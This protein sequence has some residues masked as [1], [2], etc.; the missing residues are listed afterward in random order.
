MAGREQIAVVRHVPLSVLN[1]RIKH[2]KG[3]PQVVP[4]LVFIRL[5]Y[6]GMSV[7]DAAE[8]VGSLIRLVTTGR[9]AGTRRGRSG[10]FRSMPVATLRN[11]L[12]SR[13][14]LCLKNSGRK[15]TGRPP[16]SSTGSSRSSAS[17]T[18]WTRSGGSSNRLACSPGNPIRG[19]TADPSMQNRCSL[20]KVFHLFF[21]TVKVCCTG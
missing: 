1:K 5:R 13:K 12:T 2:P 4:R 10:W 6:K 9:N 15:K 8:T 16:K 11:S 18:V 17:V 14:P 19:I 3:L 21:K 7:V 20:Q